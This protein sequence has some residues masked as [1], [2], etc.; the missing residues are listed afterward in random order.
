MES[1][2]RPCALLVMVEERS[3]EL[4]V[5]RTLPPRLIALPCRE[6][7]FGSLALGFHL[8]FALPRRQRLVVGSLG[9]GTARAWMKTQPLKN[10]YPGYGNCCGKHQ[11]PAQPAPESPPSEPKKWCACPQ[12]SFAK[13]LNQCFFH[14]DR[15]ALGMKGAGERLQ[16]LRELGLFIE[17][18]GAP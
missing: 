6:A 4:S 8:P 3:L 13:S 9:W 7:R 16:S 2:L 14:A 18:Q 11:S 15:R 5:R 1:T 12:G 17:S 10:D